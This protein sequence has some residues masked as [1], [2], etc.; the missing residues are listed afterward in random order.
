MNK[1]RQ[2]ALKEDIKELRENQKI[3]MEEP[4]KSL[5]TDF[6]AFSLV[7]LRRSYTSAFKYFRK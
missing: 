4:K 1:T 7:A 2:E 6:G 5:S 3:K